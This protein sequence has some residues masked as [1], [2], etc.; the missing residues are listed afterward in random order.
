MVK[1]ISTSMDLEDL[2][3]CEANNLKVATLIRERCSQIRADDLRYDKRI[4]E[5]RKEKELILEQRNKALR[6]I[7]HKNQWAEY[8]SFK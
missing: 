8:E 2:K 5:L 4:A 7:V 6:F 1:R 3:Y